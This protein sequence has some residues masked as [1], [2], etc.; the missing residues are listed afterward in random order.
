MG[1]PKKTDIFFGMTGMRTKTAALMRRAGNSGENPRPKWEEFMRDAN[2]DI[3]IN[4]FVAD[5]AAETLEI[6]DSI[7]PDL[8]AMEKGEA[9]S[10]DLINRVFR[11]VHSIKGGAGFS[12]FDSLKDLSH[13]ME[14]VIMRI[15]DGLLGLDPA[16]MDALLA[17][18]DKIRMMMSDIRSGVQVSCD[19]EFRKFEE[20][21]EKNS[22]KQKIDTAFSKTGPAPDTLLEAGEF[23]AC[24]EDVSNERLIDD[25]VEE[26]REILDS[27]DTD[28][29]EMEQSGE[30]ATPELADRVFKAIHNLRS[31]ADFCGFDDLGRLGRAMENG[32]SAIREDRV[33]KGRMIDALLAA[34]EKIRM[35]IDA[36]H[37]N[38]DVSYADELELIDRAAKSGVSSPIA[39]SE[40]GK[41]KDGF[42]SGRSAEFPSAAGVPDSPERSECGLAEN[43]EGGKTPQITKRAPAFSADTIRV[44]V[45]LVDRLMNLAGELVLGRNQLRRN[46]DGQMRD[47]S[48]VAPIMQNVDVVTSEIQENIM[49]MRMQPM[50]NIFN[51]FPRIVRDLSRQVGKEAEVEIDGGDVELDKTILEGLST[52]LTHLVRN[53]VD[54]GIETPDIRLKKGKPACGRISLRAFHEGGQVNIVVRDDGR[55]ID[56][57]KAVEKAVSGNMISREQ[58]DRMSDRERLDII[59]L[60][61]LSTTEKVTDISGRGV[62]MDVVKTEI[63]KIGGHIDL[64]SSSDM[65]T[66]IHIIIPLT[67]AI[68]PSLIVE[69]GKSRFAIPQINVQELVCIKAGEASQRLEKI[70]DS[71]VMRLRGKLLPILRLADLL[72][73]KGT[74]V[75]PRSGELREDRRERVVDRRSREPSNPNAGKIAGTSDK[76]RRTGGDRR[77]SWRSDMYVVV[78]KVGSNSF[79]LCVDALHDNEEIVVKPLS[80]HIKNCKSF[81]G[82][83][84]M[85]DGRV[86]MILDA[87]G[88]ASRAKLRFGE[89]KSEERRRLNVQMRDKHIYGANRQSVIIFNNAPDEYFALPLNTISRLELV[90]PDMIRQIGEQEFLTYRGDGLPLLRLEKILP[91]RPMPEGLGECYV[92]IPKSAHSQIGILASKILD[93]FELDIA[94]K[95]YS[96]I[97]RGFLGSAMVDQCLVFFLNIDELLEMFQKEILTAASVAINGNMEGIFQADA[98]DGGQ[99]V[100]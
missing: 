54:H 100:E 88:I 17:G 38:R 89:I 51:K 45:E 27:T 94:F 74:Y 29:I 41:K 72:G 69:V 76:L 58:T 32:I 12:G 42:P 4:D 21:L 79:G 87:A 20:I 31:G 66:V 37:D 62:G 36:I 78:L 85:G 81:S 82:A 70:G 95:K 43:S 47:D 11:A 97:T 50:G 6:L 65:G 3:L 16:T 5:F 34:M 18:V 30:T 68:I 53:C 28:L 52:P 8:L 46:L 7:E 96:T 73:I 90:K 33:P 39:I 15:R 2:D 83:T 22:G 35:M 19:N 93:T 55:G 48:N 86:A 67:L 99:I 23:P 59:F 25:F 14:N 26:M 24:S 40:S 64:E 61:G 13:A 56:I 9:V 60:P 77:Q 84:I 91:V 1:M 71:D 98:E 63:E 49:R 92:L 80:K 75:H 44:P 10:R 57:R